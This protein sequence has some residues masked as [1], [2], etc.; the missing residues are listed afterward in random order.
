LAP[1]ERPEA[2][3]VR[4]VC[5]NLVAAGQRAAVE[6]L[7]AAAPRAM[8]AV[9]RPLLAASAAARAAR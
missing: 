3:Y 4:R 7:A 6:R 9:V 8:A 1:W 2:R 5:A